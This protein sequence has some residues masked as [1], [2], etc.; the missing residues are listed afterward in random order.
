MEC[1]RIYP[2]SEVLKR[3]IRYAHSVSKIRCRWCPYEVSTNVRFRRVKHK[4]TM[5]WYKFHVETA[6]PLKD[7]SFR[8]DHRNETKKGFS[9][10]RKSHHTDTSVPWKGKSRTGSKV[11]SVVKTVN[12]V[13]KE[14]ISPRVEKAV[15][16]LS[17]LRAVTL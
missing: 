8:Q 1:F 10:A 16:I 4:K 3:H 14:N 2:T 11:K 5:H 13:E 9:G 12:N 6:A 17:P 15:E 7:T